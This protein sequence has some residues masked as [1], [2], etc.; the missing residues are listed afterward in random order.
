MTTGGT[1]SIPVNSRVTGA[2]STAA[3]ATA[4]VTGVSSSSVT[5]GAPLAVSHCHVK[6]G[7]AEGGP[8]EV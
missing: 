8:I 4:P 2:L 5:C 3:G 7:A 6:D 1:S